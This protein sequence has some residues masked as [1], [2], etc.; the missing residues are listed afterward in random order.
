MIIVSQNRRVI[1]NFN[2]IECIDIRKDYEG[3]KKCFSLVTLKENNNVCLASYKTEERAKEVLAEIA[4]RY[5]N[6]ENFLAGQP[7]GICS[8]KYEMPLE[9]RII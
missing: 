1:V 3:R 8:P 6:W 5:S 2:Q 4:E 7:Q 9:W